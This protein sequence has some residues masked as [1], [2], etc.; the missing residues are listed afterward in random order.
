MSR[1]GYYSPLWIGF[2]VGLILLKSM[3]AQGPE[4]ESLVY[5]SK[6]LGG[7]VIAAFVTQ[8]GM[9]GA[10]GAFAQVMPATGGRSIRGR[11]AVVSGVCIL[12]AI[13]S[14]AVSGFLFADSTTEGTNL[15]GVVVACLAGALLVAAGVS[16]FWGM[17]AAVDDFGG[18]D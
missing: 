7:A 5:W 17:P 15:A 11:V 13:V 12:A 10:Q 8:L 6:L 3:I 16:Y 18:K 2:V 9:L 14:A 4:E 1:W